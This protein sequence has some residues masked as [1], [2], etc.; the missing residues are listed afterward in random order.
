MKDK[1]QNLIFYCFTAL[2]AISIAY[3]VKVLPDHT[4]AVFLYPHA[5]ITEIFYN[6]SLLYVKGIGYSSIDGTFAIGRECMGIKFI[7][8]LFGMT[9]CMFVKHFKGFQKVLW[10]MV[11]LAGAILIGIFIS[12]IRIIGSIPL[13][14]H[15]KFPLFHSSIGISLYFLALMLSY[16]LLN[17]L[18]RSDHHE[19]VI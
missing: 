4:I 17:R 8:M 18:F 15:P 1:I 2:L 10:C 14:S 13:V 3:W 11:S 19:K 5:K 9:A 16:T 12:C 6:T 7:V